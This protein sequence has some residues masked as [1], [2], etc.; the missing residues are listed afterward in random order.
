MVFSGKGGEAGMLCAVSVFVLLV[1][2]VVAQVAS[3]RDQQV[4]VTGSPYHHREY[5][6]YRSSS[7]LNSSQR[8]TCVNSTTPSV[9]GRPSNSHQP[10]GRATVKIR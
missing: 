7:Q 1:L 4:T 2:T 8:M 9:A 10:A 3:S 5:V 6:P